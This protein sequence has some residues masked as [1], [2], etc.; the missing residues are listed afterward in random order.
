MEIIST[1]KIQWNLRITII[2]ISTMKMR[3]MNNIKIINRAMNNMKTIRM[4]NMKIKEQ[5]QPKNN[6]KSYPI[7]DFYNNCINP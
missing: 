5:T 4:I 6:F 1:I 7:M 3:A 2:K